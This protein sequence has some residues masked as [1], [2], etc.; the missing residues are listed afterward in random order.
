MVNIFSSRG[1]LRRSASVHCKFFFFFNIS[2]QPLNSKLHCLHSSIC[3]KIQRN[4][5]LEVE[6]APT[7]PAALITTLPVTLG[8]LLLHLA[9]TCLNIT[10]RK[11]RGLCSLLLLS[12][13]WEFLIQ[14]LLFTKKPL[15][16][17][18]KKCCLN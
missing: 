3:S 17:K 11:G 18:K 4:Y 13:T 14:V 5:C 12:C 1:F 16:K 2:A 15:K 9:Q 6:F 7:L 8:C 10:R